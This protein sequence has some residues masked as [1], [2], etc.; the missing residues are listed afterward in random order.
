MSS[1]GELEVLPVFQCKIQCSYFP[2]L[3]GFQNA[4]ASAMKARVAD[5]S[6]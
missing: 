3:W 4:S 2:F 1:V 6:L 5:T